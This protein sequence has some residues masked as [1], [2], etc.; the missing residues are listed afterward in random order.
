L[1]RR[2]GF[3][4][5]SRSSE[6]KIFEEMQ[7]RRAAMSDDINYCDSNQGQQERR[8]FFRINTNFV[9]SYYVYPGHINK[10][11]MTLTRNV[12]L[13]GICFTTDRHFPPGTL[14][15]VTLRLPKVTR[16]IETLGEVVYVKQERNKKLL[17]DLGIK[18]I[19][20]AEEDLFLLESIIKDCASSQTKIQMELR[21]KDSD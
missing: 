2:L 9:V 10:Q 16:L 1:K 15:H 3:V 21:E 17:F 18:F 19:Q 5:G 11:D 8:R 7:G 13:G 20:I 12:S 6:Q 14:L 4:E